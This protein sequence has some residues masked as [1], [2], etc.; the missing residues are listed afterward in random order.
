MRNNLIRA[1]SYLDTVAKI[2]TILAQAGKKVMA[3][4]KAD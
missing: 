2:L 3:L 1:F 4:C